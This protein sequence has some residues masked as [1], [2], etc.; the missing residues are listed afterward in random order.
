[1]KKVI[2]I[3]YLFNFI[4]Y[5]QS[6]DPNVILENVKET[7][8]KVKDYEVNVKIK[9]DVEFLKVPVSNAK[10]YFKQPDKIHLESENF[11]LIPREGLNFSPFSMLQENYSAIFEKEDTIDGYKTAV[12]KVIPSTETENIILSTLWIDQS[13]NIVRRI[14]S[15]TKFNGTFSIDLKYESSQT[16]YMLPTQ[17]IFTFNVDRLN[18]PKGMSGEINTD[19]DKKNDSKTTTGKVYITY[20]N[21]KVN[22]GIPDKIFEEKKNK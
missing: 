19:E 7:F 4:V 20:S 16:D 12:V 9:V 6:K 11:A 5:S 22:Q 17:M 21:Y 3:I 18:I 13:K 1:M 14:E 2:L 8:D 15:S 10:I